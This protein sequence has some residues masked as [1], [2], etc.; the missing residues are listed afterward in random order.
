MCL[1]MEKDKIKF[2]KLDKKLDT[3]EKLCKTNIAGHNYSK[4]RV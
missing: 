2:K 3:E 4:E 1:D